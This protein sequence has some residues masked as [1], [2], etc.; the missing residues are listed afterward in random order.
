MF[1][2]DDDDKEKYKALTADEMARF[3]HINI[4]GTDDTFTLPVAHATG[5]F[6]VKIPE[7]LL[8]LAFN[9]NG[10]VENKYQDA[11]K[12][13]M[14]NQ[15]LPIP[16]TG[17]AGAVIQHLQNKNFLGSPIIPTTEEGK[18]S[19]DQYLPNTPL[20]YKELGK[21]TGL[22]PLLTQHYTKALLGYMETAMAGAAQIALWDKKRWGEMPY[23]SSADYTHATFFKQFYQYK[24]DKRTSYTEEYY[25]DRDKIKE[26]ATTLEGAKKNITIEGVKRYKELIEDKDFVKVA[27]LQKQITGID[28]KVSEIKDKEEKIYFNKNLTAKEKEEKIQILYKQSTNALK[29]EYESIHP[30]LK[31]VK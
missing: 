14:L 11:V 2:G 1:F 10:I 13:A 19:S 31:E 3:S 26:A 23:S 8:N 20:I 12:F 4:Y 16:T 28:G 25:K 17:I 22:N 15:I 29:K 30:I 18:K 9:K 24:E 6:F 21:A 27:K 5:F 7:Y